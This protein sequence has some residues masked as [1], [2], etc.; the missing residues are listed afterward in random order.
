[1]LPSP[2]RLSLRHCHVSEDFNWRCHDMDTVRIVERRQRTPTDHRVLGHQPVQQLE[3]GPA[4]LALV[5]V[6]VER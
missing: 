2:I 5:D 1:M 3:Q 4:L 6:A